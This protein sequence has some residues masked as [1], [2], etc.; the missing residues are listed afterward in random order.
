M[1]IKFTHAAAKNGKHDSE[2]EKFIFDLNSG[3]SIILYEGFDDINFKTLKHSKQVGAEIAC[4]FQNTF[5]QGKTIYNP[6]ELII[7]NKAIVD[8]S[9]RKKSDFQFVLIF[10]S[11]GILVLLVS[12]YLLSA[13]IYVIRK[14]D[15]NPKQ[16]SAKRILGNWFLS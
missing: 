1:L 4:K 8:Y 11:V 15:F 13:V 10:L 9:K 6:K 2:S 3:E 16:K 5:R 7:N 14:A 12:V